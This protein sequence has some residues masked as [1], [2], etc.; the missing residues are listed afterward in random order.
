MARRWWKSGHLKPGE[1][2]VEPG[3][4]VVHEKGWLLRMCING[5]GA[6]LT[7]IVM[8]I[9]AVTKFKDGAWVVVVLIPLLVSGFFAIHHHYKGLAKQLSLDNH[10]YQKTMDTQPGDHADRWGAQWHVDGIEVCQHTINGL[11]SSAYQY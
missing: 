2:L 3:S 8:I 7:G 6:I 9:F 10:V 4:N 11:D 1:Q 5:F